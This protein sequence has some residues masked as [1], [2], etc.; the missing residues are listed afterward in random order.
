MQAQR[1]ALVPET[2]DARLQ[3]RAHLTALFALVAH[4]LVDLVLRRQGLRA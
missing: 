1:D 2:V 4:D 3:L